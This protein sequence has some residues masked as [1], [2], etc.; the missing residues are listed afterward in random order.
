MVSGIVM[1]ELLDKVVGVYL[2]LFILTI[3]LFHALGRILVILINFDG[4]Y[5]LFLHL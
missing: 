1:I 2:L 3:Q 5:R 4:E